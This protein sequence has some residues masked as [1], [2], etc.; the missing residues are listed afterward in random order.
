M[1]QPLASLKNSN[2]EQQLLEIGYVV[3][4]FFDQNAID[5]LLDV[6][7]SI[8]NKGVKGIFANTH[9]SDLEFKHALNSRIKE[10]Y[11]PFVEKFFND[12]LVLGGSLITKPVGGGVSHPHLDWNLV[13]EGP[14]RSCNVWVPLV[15]LNE[16]NGAI[17]VL[18]GSHQLFPTYRGPNIPDR[19]NDLQQFY[20]DNM[21]TLYLK[22]GEALIYD[23]RLLHGSK[24]NMSNSIRPA[25]A[26]AVT[27]KS[28]ALRL[29]YWNDIVKKIEIFEGENIEHLLSNDRFDRPKT[30]R[31]LGFVDNYDMEQITEDDYSFLKLKPKSLWSKLR[32]YFLK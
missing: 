22:A 24:D 23:H 25:S 10:I 17:E 29:Y 26:C 31:S 20:W 18:D 4:P 14:F 11:A 15:D 19:T 7:E 13:E 5:S 30:M 8:S 27:N 3:V 16:K 2:L 6:N 28:A 9:L 1:Q 21:K 12:P 32:T